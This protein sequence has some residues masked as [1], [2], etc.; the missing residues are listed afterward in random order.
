LEVPPEQVE[1][2]RALVSRHFTI[3][4]VF[5]EEGGLAFRVLE[6]EIKDRFKSLWRDLSKL[7]Y[8]PVS[9]RDEA[10][11]KVKVHRLQKK[12]WRWTP[13]PFILLLATVATT[14]FDG[15]L[16]SLGGGDLL[17]P[18]YNDPLFNAALY[19]TAVMA[20]IGIHELGHKI[21]ARIDGIETSLPYFIPGIPGAIPTFGAVI[22]QRGPIAN[23]DDLFDLGV[24]GPVAGFAVALVVTYLSYSTATWLPADEVVKLV[25]QGRAMLLG[26]PLIFG[27]FHVFMG[28][29]NLVPIFPPF[30][31]AAWL[32]MVVTSLNLLPIWQLDGG[33][34]FRSFLSRRAHLIASYVCVG[35]LALTGYYFFAIILLLMMRI[36]AD[37]PVLDNV[38]PLSR[39]RKVAV[40]GVMA[41]I[42]VTFVVMWLPLPLRR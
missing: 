42:V 18:P 9:E 12:T 41:M 5:Y 32:G 6:T 14:F 39:G 19:A 40:A 38:S 3:T 16:K 20:I 24:S 22:F 25:E 35:L 36:P 15:Y 34:I 33:R 2:I 30:G 28:R 1:E 8:I 21:S 10:G 17:R 23:R 29:G 11:V 31:F 4:D 7:G 26:A 37:I 27:L 13:T